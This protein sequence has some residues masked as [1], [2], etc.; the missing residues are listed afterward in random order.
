ML[1][2]KKPN[3]WTSLDGNTF[4]Q[5]VIENPNIYPQQTDTQKEKVQNAIKALKALKQP[6]ASPFYAILMMDGDSLGKQMSNRANQDPI[7]ESLKKFTNGVQSIVKKHNGVL[8]YA[9][10]DDVLAIFPLEDALNCA[11]K[12]RQYYLECFACHKNDEDGQQVFSTLSGA[13]EYAHITIPLTKILFDAHHLLDDI[14][15]EKTG[16]DSIAIRVQKPGGLA[17]EWSQP[18]K[19]ALENNELIIEKL[20]NTFRD[21]ATND[22][23]FSSKFFYKIRERFEVLNPSKDKKGNLRHEAVLSETEAIDLMCMEYLNSGKTTFTTIDEA[24]K[25][26]KLL[27]KQCRR[28]T[29]KMNK[30]NKEEA[31]SNWE[32]SDV[33]RVDA[34]LLVRFLANKGI[35]R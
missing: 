16:R 18:W 13:I 27:L 28:F 11:A 8:I 26:T 19:I 33:L 20:A 30:D 34:A 24:K 31:I 4:H 15:K 9:G 10:G 7:T 21:V 2:L 1:A 6:P 12:L 32:R 5:F 3:K 25:T 17:L 29:R 22:P 35:E 23:T 14:A